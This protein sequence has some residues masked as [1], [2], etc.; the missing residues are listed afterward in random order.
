MVW[1]VPVA[2]VLATVLPDCNRRRDDVGLSTQS[3]HHHPP[4]KPSDLETHQ[5]CVAS[6][7]I[8]AAPL[9]LVWIVL[10]APWIG[11]TSAV[12]ETSPPSLGQC[13]EILRSSIPIDFLR[14]LH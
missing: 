3:Q 5:Q 4:P 8:A 10:L 14:L 2:L 12:S 7:S 11:P 6:P 1:T 13:P 9:A